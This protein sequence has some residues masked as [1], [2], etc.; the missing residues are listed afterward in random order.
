MKINIEKLRESLLERLPKTPTPMIDEVIRQ[1]EVGGDVELLARAVFVP[2]VL[3]ESDHMGMLR[4]IDYEVQT[5]ANDI[6]HTSIQVLMAIH[7][8]REPNDEK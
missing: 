3:L 8:A 5:L 7:D 4:A 2:A 1:V 6:K